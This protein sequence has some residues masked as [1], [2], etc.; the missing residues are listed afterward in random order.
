[1]FWNDSNNSEEQIKFG[2]YL[3]P[4]NSEYFF[5]STF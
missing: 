4:L 3:L 5:P 2:E 1:M